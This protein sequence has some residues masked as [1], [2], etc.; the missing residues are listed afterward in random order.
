MPRW[1]SLPDFNLYTL[2]V[3]SKLRR[4]HALN[5]GDAVGK[6]AFVVHAQVVFEYIN[7]F[8]YVVEEEVCG[9]VAG[10]LV[11]AEV[12]LPFVL[13]ENVNGFESGGTHVFHVDEFHGPVG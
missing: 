6:A 11:A 8:R 10:A 1:L 7:A 5:A 2:T 13:G 12:F 3:T 4:I 9:C